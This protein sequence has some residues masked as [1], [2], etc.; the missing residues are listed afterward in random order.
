[1]Y[2]TDDIE[3]REGLHSAGTQDK[4]DAEDKQED[5]LVTSSYA[6]ARYK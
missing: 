5:V 2:F 4:P 3:R 6:R 1:M